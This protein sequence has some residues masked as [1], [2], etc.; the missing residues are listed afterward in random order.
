MSVCIIKR[1][2]HFNYQQALNILFHLARC[3]MLDNNIGQK[4]KYSQ[5]SKLSTIIMPFSSDCPQTVRYIW[6]C[7]CNRSR[8]CLSWVLLLRKLILYYVG[9]RKGKITAYI[10]NER[11]SPL[12]TDMYE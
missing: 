7:L 11:Y 5:I 4:Q 10:M 6:I 1:L 3:R 12:F 2:L 9:L 8:T